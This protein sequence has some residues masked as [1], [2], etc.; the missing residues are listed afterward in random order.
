MMTNTVQLIRATKWYKMQYGG[1]AR[2]AQ[3][4]LPLSPNYG[5]FGG[6]GFYV[7]SKLGL[8][9]LSTISCPLHGLTA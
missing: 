2:P 8:E 9:S 3:V 5:N 7:E 4:I 1:D 6:D